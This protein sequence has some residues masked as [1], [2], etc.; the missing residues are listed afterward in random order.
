MIKVLVYLRVSDQMQEDRDSLSKQEE[1]VLA[2]CRFKKYKIYKI[3]KEVG[4]GRRD[5]R[6][7]FQ[8]LENE[9][10][11]NKFDLLVFY[12]LSRLARN[13]FLLHKLMN[14]LELNNIKFESVTES[15]L[16][17]ESP[18]SKMIFSFLASIA[19]MDS[20]TISKNVTTRMLWYT[21]QGY[22]KFQPPRGYDLGED[23]IL[24]P[25]E[26]AFK[27]VDMF[28]DFLAGNSYAELCRKYHLSHPGIK[29]G[30]TNVAY[31][32]KTKFGFEGTNKKSGKRMVGLNGQT[33]D[34]KHEAIVD[35]ELFDAVQDLVKDKEKKRISHIKGEYLLSGLARHHSCPRRMTGK[36]QKRKYGFYRFYV[37]STCGKPSV[38]AD[39]LEKIVLDN[40]NEYS[41]SLNSLKATRKKAII[42]NHNKKLSSLKN[43]KNRTFEVYMDGYIARDRYLKEIKDIEKEIENIEQKI[44]TQNNVEKTTNNYDN[45]LKLLK[46]FNSKNIEEKNIILKLFIDEIK[47]IDKDNIE[48]IYKV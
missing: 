32:G 39:V 5:D 4:S 9:I 33:F 44:S 19:E 48:I 24:Y 6:E 7:G 23:G 26:E 17:S 22:W 42:N 15:Y 20:D 29:R 10:K 35:A 47:I 46:K 25:N 13:A 1:Q 12:Q 30:L 18:V 8:E 3:I 45:L 36:R 37:C 31:I 14:D 28:E 38:S 21:S 2:Y 43:K 40:L 11:F 34:G 41:K 27:V 16:N